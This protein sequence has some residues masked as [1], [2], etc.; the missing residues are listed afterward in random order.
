MPDCGLLLVS[1][2]SIMVRIRSMLSISAPRE[3]T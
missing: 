1:T 2:V 3:V